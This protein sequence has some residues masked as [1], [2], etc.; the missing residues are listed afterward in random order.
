MAADDEK[1]PNLDGEF[2]VDALTGK[3]RKRR[4]PRHSPLRHRQR[5]EYGRPR[6]GNWQILTGKEYGRI[7]SIFAKIPDHDR[8][9]MFFEVWN[10]LREISRISARYVKVEYEEGAIVDALC[11]WLAG[12]ESEQPVV[13]AD[14]HL[15]TLLA[16]AC[17]HGIYSLPLYRP[18]IVQ[19]ALDFQSQEH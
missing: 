13:S 9:L 10:A 18:R 4:V 14:E 1:R 11:A 17:T 7:L 2:Y 15:L 8:E 12:Q 6:Q 5:D 3:R 16:C 19:K